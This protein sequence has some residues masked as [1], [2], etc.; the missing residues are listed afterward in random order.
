MATWYVTPCPVC[1]SLI[2]FND[3]KLYRQVEC[4]DCAEVFVV[5]SLDPV[6]LTYA[7][8]INHDPHYYDEDYPRN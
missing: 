7:F 8:D 2:N 4:P 6:K 3:A 1:D 5:L